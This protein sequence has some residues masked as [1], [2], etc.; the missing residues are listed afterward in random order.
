M[1][2]HFARSFNLDIVPGGMNEDFYVK[3]KEKL[4]LKG[5]G[6]IIEKDIN[7]ESPFKR[8]CCNCL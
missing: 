6:Q 5:Y 1:L 7:S 4:F 3:T 2:I 8:R